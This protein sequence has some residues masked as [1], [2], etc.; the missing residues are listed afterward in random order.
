MMGQSDAREYV[1]TLLSQDKVKD[2]VEYHCNGSVRLKV[3]RVVLVR[4]FSDPLLGALY[5]PSTNEIFLARWLLPD[6]EVCASTLRH[7][8]G[9]FI[10]VTTG[11][12]GPKHGYYYQKALRV[13][14]PRLWFDDSR[15]WTPT[16]KVMAERVR[17]G[18][19][20]IPGL[21]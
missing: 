13:I 4:S 19:D 3:P 12:R 21:L 5:K 6:D 10:H 15:G 9:H 14:S 18:L 11:D 20:P 16:E 8:G 17:L 2:Y 7:E 1:A